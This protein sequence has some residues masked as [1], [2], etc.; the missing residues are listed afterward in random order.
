VAKARL[1]VA[2]ATTH[3]S[4]GWHEVTAISGGC[5]ATAFCTRIPSAMGI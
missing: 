3:R 4:Q 2:L 5:T 1:L